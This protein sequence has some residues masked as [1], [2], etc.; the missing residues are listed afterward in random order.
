MKRGLNTIS[1]KL[2]SSHCIGVTMDLSAWWNSSRLCRR[3]KWYAWWSGTNGTF[4][5][6]TSWRVI[7]KKQRGMLSAGVVLLHH[8]ARPHKARRSTHLL[9]E[10]SWELFNHPLYSSDLGASDFHLFLHFKKFLSGQLQRFQNDGEEEMSVIHW[11]Q[12]QAADCYD[13]GKQKLVPRYNKYL[14]FIGEYIETYSSSTLVVSVPINP[15][16]ICVLFL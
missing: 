6:S 7:Q 4:S 3:G 8:N 13:T 16:L 5:T 11:F 2:S 10:F 12:C 9:Q 15:S 1:H 14:S